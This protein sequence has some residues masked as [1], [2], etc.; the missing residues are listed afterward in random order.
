MTA[1]IEL[2]TVAID[3]LQPDP[4]NARVHS[5][6]NI[7]AIAKSLSTFGQRKPIVVAGGTIVAGNGTVEAA[8]RIGWTHITA[9]EYPA[10]RITEARAYAIAD[11]R[12][13]E[14]SLWDNNRLK[15]QLENL[16]T[17][18][19]TVAGFTWEEIDDLVSPSVRVTE[20]TLTEGDKAIADFYAMRAARSFTFRLPVAQY[21]WA[22]ER[23]REVRTRLGVESNADAVERL[24]L[25]AISSEEAR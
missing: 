22:I 9:V 24:I 3:E 2:R 25:D 6:R 15:A 5:E 19:A 18:L 12:T 1:P 21:E 14:L 7:N 23:L 11:N 10:D 17:G 16:G 20:L 4:E 13:G 8:R